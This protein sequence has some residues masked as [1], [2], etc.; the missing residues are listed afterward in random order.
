MSIEKPLRHAT[1]LLARPNR[2]ERR[3]VTRH[4]VNGS[5]LTRR[6]RRVEKREASL[7]QITVNKG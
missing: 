4:A 7:K 5:R 6:S 3:L 1:I 2:L